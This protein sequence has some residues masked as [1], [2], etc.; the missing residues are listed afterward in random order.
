M[1]TYFMVL[2]SRLLLFFKIIPIVL[3]VTNIISPTSFNAA[4][5]EPLI[6]DP[7]LK[8]E[9]VATGLDF[10][11]AMA[12]Y[13]SNDALVLEKNTGQV[14]R[15]QNRSEFNGP[16]LGLNVANQSERG[17]LGIAVTENAP[18]PKYVFLYFTETDAKNAS[19]V[20]GNRLYRYDLIDNNT[21]MVNPKL[22]V[23]LPYLPGSSHNGGV[24]KIGPDKKSL[25]LAI[26]DVNSRSSLT[27]NVKTGQAFDGRG[28]ILRV[29]L[30]GEVVG[31]KGI[32]GDNQSLNKYYAY[33]IRNS[34]G[35]DFDPVTG[36]LWDTENGPGFGDE[37][38]LVQPGFNSGW[39]KVQGIWTVTEEELRGVTASKEPNNLVNF[40][41][42]GKYSTPEFIWNRSVGVTALKFLD[43]D[44]L[45]KK[46]KNDLFVGDFHK[47]N[48]YHFDL[49][50]MR[51]K[52][53]LHD[54]LQDQ[55][56]NSPKEL[57]KSDI[58]FGQ[59]FGGITDIDVGPT[60]GFLYLLSINQ[61]GGDCQKVHKP[62]CIQYN[63]TIEGTI[64][65]IVPAR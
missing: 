34:F 19:K 5:G 15:I 43:S 12:F 50:T 53:L 35:M 39:K 17:L 18:E 30:D 60:D 56:A 65:R 23:S 45:G 41:G 22:I 40:D 7:N 46:Y 57:Q 32:L 51:T 33:G 1:I 54:S 36:K 52:L 14:V 3:L 16:L 47:G 29:T 26:G 6:N 9:T 62:T 24:L 48:L 8:V 11:T 25:Y 64:F 13:G 49:N 28:G 20:L 21:K 4:N 27:Q 55:I 63:S 44:K 2:W 58:I 42:K 31:G 59:G 37:I 61:G 10:P 38:N